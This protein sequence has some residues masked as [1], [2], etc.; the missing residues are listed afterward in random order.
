MQDPTSRHKPTPWSI[1]PTWG[2]TVT[3]PRLHLTPSGDGADELRL[4]VHDRRAAHD[5]DDPLGWIMI[6]EL[7][8]PIASAGLQ[9]HILPEHRRR[10]LATEALAHLCSIALTAAAPSG[11]SR[12]GWGLNRLHMTAA[13]SDVASRGLARRL[14]LTREMRRRQDRWVEGVG[15]DD[16]YGWSVIADEWDAAAHR[17]RRAAPEAD[18]GLGPHPLPWPEDERLDPLLLRDGDRRN[19]ADRYRYWRHEAV[20]ADLADRAHPF[21]IAIENWRHDNNIGTVVRNANAF[22]AAGVHVVGRRSWNRRGAMVTDRYLSVHHHTDAVALARWADEH[23]L[24]L[25]GI[26]NL[27]GSVSLHDHPPPRDCMLLMG[28]EGPGL[29]DQARAAVT[30]ILHIPQFG[31]TRSINAGVASG[32]AMATWVQVHA[33]GEDDRAY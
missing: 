13:G 19:V 26:D 17:M 4:E 16:T 2:T 8:A 29:S 28:Q 23:E 3:T 11:T 1:P 6:D 32:I 15:V 14:G 33:T 27:P 5:P 18:V 21:H 20:V 25:I 22:G 30:R 10:G 9:I 31:S 12:G 7:D 24:A